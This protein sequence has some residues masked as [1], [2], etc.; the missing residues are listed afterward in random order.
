MLRD[1][2]WAASEARGAEGDDVRQVQAVMKMHDIHVAA[3]ACES[4]ERRGRPQRVGKP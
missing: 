2:H 1:E 3:S 4:R